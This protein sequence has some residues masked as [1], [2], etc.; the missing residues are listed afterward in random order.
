MEYF[1]FFSTVQFFVIVGVCLAIVYRERLIKFEQRVMSAIS[2]RR[3]SRQA[4]ELESIGMSVVPAP[5]MTKE[6][7]I[8]IMKEV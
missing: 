7:V 1:G 6:E 3:H 4:R 5:A 2:S 8:R